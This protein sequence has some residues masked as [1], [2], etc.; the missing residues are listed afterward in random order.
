MTD[1]ERFGDIIDTLVGEPAVT[2]PEGGP[3]FGSNGLKVN[4]H[5]FA[6]LVRG[7]LV[8]KLPRSRVDGLI[9]SGRGHV[10]DAGKGRPMKEWVSLDG[11]ADWLAF[12]REAMEFVRS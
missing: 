7:Q 9:D 8:L 10:F 3:K 6:M 12:A 2:P 1:E 4:G 11:N 5:L